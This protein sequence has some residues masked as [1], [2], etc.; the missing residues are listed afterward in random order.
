MAWAKGMPS[1]LG[2]TRVK[3]GLLV[4]DL[5]LLSGKVGLE[6]EISSI[7]DAS[8]EVEADRDPFAVEEGFV[9]DEVEELDL[10]PPTRLTRRF[11][12][13]NAR[14]VMSFELSG[15]MFIAR[16]GSGPP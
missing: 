9:V 5:A 16:V 6:L 1:H 11:S 15:S 8:D 4:D 7:P 12:I 14:N 3:G 10:S 2:R 13:L